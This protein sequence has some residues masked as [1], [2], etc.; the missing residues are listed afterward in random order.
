MWKIHNGRLIQTSDESRMRYKTRISALIVEQ[1]KQMAQDHDTHISYLLENG[2][3]NLLEEGF[4]TFNKKNR[5]KD[6]IE[7]RTT[8]DQELLQCLKDFAKAK[9][10]NLNDCIEASIAYINVSDVKHANWRYRIES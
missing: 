4:I 5:P 6:R 3:S 1:L 7:F 2:Y 10:L 8:C 9:D